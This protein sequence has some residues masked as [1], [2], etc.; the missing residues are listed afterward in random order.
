MFPFKRVG[1]ET[2]IMLGLLE[3][4]NL[5]HWM[6]SIIPVIPEGILHPENLSESF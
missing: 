5:N 6:K 4:A 1:R 3:G 2:P